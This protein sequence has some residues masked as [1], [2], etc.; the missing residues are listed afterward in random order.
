M[1]LAETIARVKARKAHIA[2]LSERDLRMLVTYLCGYAPE[3][4][5]AAL[6]ELD[7]GRGN[8]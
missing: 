8:L 6:D 3:A 4:V 5:D 2:A 1:S 7:D